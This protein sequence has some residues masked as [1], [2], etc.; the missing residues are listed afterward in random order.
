[1]KIL[2]ITNGFDKLTDAALETR[3]NAI[4]TAITGNPAFPT[5]TPTIA[6]LQNVLNTYSNA[7]AKAEQGSPLE[8]AVKNQKKG[9]P[10]YR[11]A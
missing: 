11:P 3:A 2:R 10:D 8:K 9:R 5:P 4:L 6:E 7:L 1:M